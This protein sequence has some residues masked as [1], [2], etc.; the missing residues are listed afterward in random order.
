MKKILLVED[1]QTIGNLVQ[2][3]LEEKGYEVTF[4]KDGESGY[5]AVHETNFDLVLLDIM[6]P[7]MNGF[8][9]LEKLNEEKVIPA[10]PVIIISNSGESVEIKRALDLG[11]RDYLV[12]VNFEPNE[13]VEKVNAVFANEKG[14]KDTDEKQGDNEGDDETNTSN[15]SDGGKESDKAHVLIVEDD[16]LLSTTLSRNFSERN[17]GP[18]VA[19][20]ASEA[21]TVLAREPGV[22]V[23]LLD[24]LLPD[25][26]GFDFL[27]ELKE[28]NKWG[29]IPVIITSNLGQKEDIEKGKELG[30]DGYFV[31]ATMLPDE[32]CDRVSE[33]IKSK[34]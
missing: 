34:K 16:E 2:L 32:I 17:M 26:N 12:K 28:T 9:V 27:K 19:T 22:K 18:I 20:S 6:L 3:A 4:V 1:E 21:R 31:K 25:V 8:E 14:G 24:V 13:V 11:I 10:L 5:S 15:E 7:G 23:I 30:A 33:M 29:D